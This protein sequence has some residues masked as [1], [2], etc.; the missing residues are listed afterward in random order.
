LPP[1]LNLP[2][3]VSTGLTATRLGD[4]V[5][6]HWTTPS[7]T[8]DKLLI[9]GP[10]VAVICREMVTSPVRTGQSGST[11]N[12]GQ[13]VATAHCAAVE[14]VPVTP[15]VSDQADQL[16][17]TLTTGPARL[18]AYRIELQNAAGRT[19]GPSTAAYAAAGAG[20]APVAEFHGRPT[21]A[22]VV[23]EWKEEP[24]SSVAIELDRVELAPA[25]GSAVPAAKAVVLA[26]KPSARVKTTPPASSEHLGGLP[27]MAKEPA[28]TRFQAGSV[29]VGGTID[30]SARIGA[31]YSYTA[32]RVHRVETGG[33][34]L[35]VRS[36]PS[37][38]VTVDVEDVFPPDAPAGLVSV[39]GMTGTAGEQ[40]AIDLSWDPNM[41]PRIIG[42]R[43]Y[44]RDLDGVTPDAWMRLEAEQ[45]R[46]SSYRDLNVVAG[47]RYA[48][49]LT[50][51]NEAGHESA[52]SE[53]VVETAP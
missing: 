10:I 1:T 9:K 12:Q 11:Q 3:V 8:T 45:V 41:E 46:I 27:G 29:D 38:V 36:V 16:P 28:E 49:R 52:A 5:K 26:P 31:R 4:E 44:R 19:A 34:T 2:A 6:L 37:A 47:H 15:G 33:L 18:L 43:V 35:E 7:L 21:K 24:G 22:G 42:Y 23:L 39:P 17:A 20:V 13:T 51:V 32:E 40:S 53:Q 14:R 25:T 50:A 48:Y 30:R